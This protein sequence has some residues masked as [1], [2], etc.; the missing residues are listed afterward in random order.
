MA[1]ALNHLNI[2]VADVKRSVDFYSR[3]FGCKERLWEGDDFVILDCGGSDLALARGRPA[4]APGFHFGFRAETKAE[5]EQWH[6]Q[7]TAQGAKIMEPW[8]E[9]ESYA[10][11]SVEDPDG[12]RVQVYWEA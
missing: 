3:L 4:F 8:L 5:A 2:V 1:F 7:L 12:Y 6:R 11:F 10:S 9:Q